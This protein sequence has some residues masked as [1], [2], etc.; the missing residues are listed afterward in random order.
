MRTTPL[1][2]S[3][4]VAVVLAALAAGWLSST[5]ILRVRALEAVPLFAPDSL[6]GHFGEAPR[7]VGKLAA[8]EELVVVDCVDRKSDINVQALYQGKVVAVGEWKAKIKLLRSHAFPW[9]QGA[10]TSCRGLF[11][12][13]SAHA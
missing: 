2:A 6:A 4:S 3:I 8:G 11:K 7:E 13:V 5:E 10:T 12:S 9:E 1:L